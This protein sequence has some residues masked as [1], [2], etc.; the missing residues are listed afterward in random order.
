M[1]FIKFA[2]FADDNNWSETSGRARTKRP[3]SRTA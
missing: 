2:A 1:N 3:G